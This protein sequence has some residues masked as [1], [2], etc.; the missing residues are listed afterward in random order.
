M[1]LEDIARVIVEEYINKEP[2]GIEGLKEFYF[3]CEGYYFYRT[4]CQYCS[5]FEDC[6]CEED[7]D[8]NEEEAEEQD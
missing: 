8:E 4:S 7:E 2:E 5:K 3:E 6:T 1:T